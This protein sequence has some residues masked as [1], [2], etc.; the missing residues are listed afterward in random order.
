MGRVAERRQG[1][2]DV[3]NGLASSPAVLISWQGA[4]ADHTELRPQPV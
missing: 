3:F 1:I 2:E 4:I